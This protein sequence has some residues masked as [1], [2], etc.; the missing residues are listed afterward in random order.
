MTSDNSP[1][2]NLVIADAVSVPATIE[3][4]LNKAITYARA[5]KSAATRRAYRSDFDLFRNWCEFKGAA[6]LPAQPE[7][8]AA[9]LASEANRGAKPSTIGRRLA[10]IR[11]AHK[12]AGHDPPTTTEPVKA[13]L[14]GIRRTNGSAPVRKLPATADKVI[15]M[16]A[17]TDT[18]LKG[19][20]D[21]A[22]LLLGFAGAFRRSELVALDVADLEFCDGG[23]RVKIRKSKTDQE[24]Q[25]A[26]I[27]IVPGSIACPV[28]STRSWLE[29]AAIAEGS[30]FRHV[31]RSGKVSDGRLSDR[32]I[33]EVVKSYA[34]RVGLNAADFSG[35]SLRSGFLTSA[36]R[37][38]ASIFKMMDVS[39]HRSIDT[40]RGYVRDAELF[41]D[42][43]GAGLL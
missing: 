4:D 29:A 32:A 37:R 31:R 3:P 23:L 39:R 40:L 36:A 35:H 13:T 30:L 20:R 8:V 14:R 16:V 24:G 28:E 34:R 17:M 18:S 5:E 12:L 41:R 1:S 26:T 19:I 22:I 11:Y 7:I 25:G 10:A 43:A 2:R 42:H 6:A 9:Y 27:A 15:A 33:A 21:R 38:G